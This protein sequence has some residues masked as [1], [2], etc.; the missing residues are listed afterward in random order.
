MINNLKMYKVLI[1]LVA[2][3]QAAYD[4]VTP[5]VPMADYSSETRTL[6]CWECFAADGFMCHDDSHN[7][8]IAKT[9]SSNRAHG[10][11]CRPGFAGEHCTSDGTHTCIPNASGGANGFDTVL[12]NGKNH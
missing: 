5:I 11:C 6:D 10:V 4:S 3:S 2:T 12:T 9:G 8:M 7:N 1:S